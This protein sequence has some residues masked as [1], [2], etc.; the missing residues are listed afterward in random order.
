MKRT[1]ENGEAMRVAEA[2]IKWIMLAAGAANC[3]TAYAA[4]APQSALLAAFGE[5][6]ATLIYGAFVP[7][8]R[9]M[10][11]A[12]AGAGKLVFVVLVLSQDARLLGQQ[13]GI[14]IA[15]DLVWVVPFAWSLLVAPTARV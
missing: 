7:Q 8:V 6:G 3:T 10:A 12:V 11:L 14:A 9:S 4:I 2:D 13:A 15:V 5:T 1:G